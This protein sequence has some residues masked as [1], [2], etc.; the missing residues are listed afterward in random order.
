MRRTATLVLAVLALVVTPSLAHSQDRLLLT[1]HRTDNG[2]A[3]SVA[4]AQPRMPILLFV[5]TKAGHT[6]VFRGTDTIRPLTVGLALPFSVLVLGV[7][8]SNGRLTLRAKVSGP[9]P[10]ALLQAV[11]PAQD[12]HNHRLIVWR[13]SAVISTVHD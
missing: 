12:V 4:G 3:V 9:L 8:D 2:V 13:R 6:T 10:K 7:A 11:S 1:L 5:G